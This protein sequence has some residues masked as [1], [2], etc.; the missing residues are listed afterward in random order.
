[1]ESVQVCVCGQSSNCQG[2]Q[3]SNIWAW[4][5]WRRGCRGGSSID[6]SHATNFSSCSGSSVFGTFRIKV[7]CHREDDFTRRQFSSEPVFCGWSPTHCWTHRTILSIPLQPTE[8]LPYVLLISSTS[9]FPNPSHE[10][11]P[12]AVIGIALV[13]IFV[14]LVVVYPMPVPNLELSHLQC[15]RWVNSRVIRDSNRRQCFASNPMSTWV[16]NGMNP[17]DI[18]Q[19]VAFSRRRTIIWDQSLYLKI[20]R[21]FLFRTFGDLIGR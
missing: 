18:N 21:H 19:Q 10:L 7:E 11:W 4:L 13:L 9:P 3:T 17:N 5:L 14:M 12:S 20:F 6:P 2:C 1:M 15:A 8:P 16:G